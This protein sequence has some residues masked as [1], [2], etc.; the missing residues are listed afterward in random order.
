MKKICLA[1]LSCFFLGINVQAQ[2]I[3]FKET[4]HDFGMIDELEGN[5]HYDFEFTNTGNEPFT[6]TNV[7]TG[8]GCTSAKWS[9]KCRF[10]CIV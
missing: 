9:N 2:K 6:I 5:V 3:T 10:G 8:C 4:E 7:I 1:L